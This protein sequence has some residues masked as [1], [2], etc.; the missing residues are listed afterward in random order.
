M[1]A[2]HG[3][4]GPSRPDEACLTIFT[5]ASDGG[6]SDRVPSLVLRGGAFGLAFDGA[7]DR[8]FDG[9]FEIPRAPAGIA[10]IG[11]HSG[12]SLG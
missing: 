6:H 5:W 7:S 11:A 9:A 3:L 4:G 1:R 12:D 8:A 2:S 10:G